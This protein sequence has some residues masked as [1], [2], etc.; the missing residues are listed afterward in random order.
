[1]TLNHDLKSYKSDYKKDIKLFKLFKNFLNGES[2]SKSSFEN[3]VFYFFVFTFSGIT[4][5]YLIAPFNILLLKLLLFL[6]VIFFAGIAI[7]IFL[8]K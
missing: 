3:A 2:K 5:L 7:I 8:N 6:K 1:M 4:L